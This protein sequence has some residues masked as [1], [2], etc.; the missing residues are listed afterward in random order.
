MRY[1]VFGKTAELYCIIDTEKYRYAWLDPSLSNDNPDVLFDMDLFIQ[2]YGKGFVNYVD[3]PLATEYHHWYVTGR[4]A[5][6]ELFLPNH[7]HKHTAEI[8]RL[9]VLTYDTFERACTELPGLLPDILIY[10]M[11]LVY[12]CLAQMFH[13]ASIKKENLQHWV[14]C[15]IYFEDND[16]VTLDDTCLI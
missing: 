15:K 13:L 8:Y 16:V 1:I 14:S 7:L 6:L 2:K 12:D 4:K 11:E 3:P 5:Y 10:N 9:S